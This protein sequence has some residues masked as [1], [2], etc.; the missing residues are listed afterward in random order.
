VADLSALQEVLGVFFNDPSLL[1]RALVHRSYV[2]EYPDSAPI[3]NERLEFLG[4]AV[5]GLVV[6]E[7]LFQDFTK[8]TE[9]KMTKLRAALVC[10][11]TLARIAGTI[12]LGG[13][14][15]LG[16][17]E[18]ASGGRHKTANLA[19]VLEAVIGAVYLDQGLVS[20][21]GFISR[22]FSQELKKVARWGAGVDYKSRLQEAVQSRG[23]TA[24]VYKVIEEEGPDHDKRFTVEVRVGKKVLGKGSGKSKKTAEVAAARFAL[25]QFAAD[26]TE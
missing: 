1:E 20:A 17:G 21:G 14:L 13:Y 19:R 11:D 26:F 12:E 5:L 2:N 15:Y 3:S 24:P 10:Q 25:G 6:A 7:K 8:L 4:D 23:Q 16:K 9:G 22:V 18:E